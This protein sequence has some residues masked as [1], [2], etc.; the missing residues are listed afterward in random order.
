M[1]NAPYKKTIDYSSRQTYIYPLNDMEKSQMFAEKPHC[2]D[3][4]V[5]DGQVS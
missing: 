4:R 2:V 1:N 5:F 3:F